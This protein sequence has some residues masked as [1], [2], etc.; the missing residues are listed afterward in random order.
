MKWTEFREGFRSTR[1]CFFCIHFQHTDLNFVKNMF[2]FYLSGTL[3]RIS[4]AFP[5][6]RVIHRILKFVRFLSLC[7]PYGDP[8]RCTC[9]HRT[10]ELST[11]YIGCFQYHLWHNFFIVIALWK[12]RI[13]LSLSLRPLQFRI[14][15]RH[16]N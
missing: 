3:F 14:R 5:A 13:L 8:C 10:L 9:W 6:L 4:L 15:H 7:V 11:G 12:I 16:L 1:I 2:C